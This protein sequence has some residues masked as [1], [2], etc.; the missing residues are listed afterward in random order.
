MT[1]DNKNDSLQAPPQSQAGLRAKK[2]HKYFRMYTPGQS[3]YMRLNSKGKTQVFMHCHQQHVYNHA[4]S[5]YFLIIMMYSA[6]VSHHI[7][8]C[9]SLI[10]RQPYTQNIFNLCEEKCVMHRTPTLLYIMNSFIQL[11]HSINDCR[12]GAFG[13]GYGQ[14]F[15]DWKI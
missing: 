1:T 9:F 8:L 12:N 5:S 2:K 11:Q 10:I 6:L 4:H 7:L 15:N 14:E 13:C 3:R